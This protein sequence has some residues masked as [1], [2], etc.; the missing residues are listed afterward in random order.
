MN[1]PDR[2]RALLAKPG[3]VLMPAVWDGLSA[4]L[5]AAAG[6]KTFVLEVN[7]EVLKKGV[8]RI[9]KFLTG[10][11]E[12]GKVTPEQK[13]TVFANLT[14]TTNFADLKDCDLVI[15][16]IVENVEVKKKTYA[17]IE[18]GWRRD[19]QLGGKDAFLRHFRDE[20]GALVLSAAEI[21]VIS[22]S[23]REAQDALLFEKSTP[24]L[25]RQALRLMQFSEV[26][27]L[28]RSFR[29]SV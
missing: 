7:D 2:L 26:W 24:S 28:Y 16:A 25:R 5:A 11:I 17:Q 29:E 13:A 21:A 18:A 19:A 20:R 10:G 8:G 4:K 3:L 1:S 23:L 12:K 15:E 22:A 9:D 27:D 6:F 14:G